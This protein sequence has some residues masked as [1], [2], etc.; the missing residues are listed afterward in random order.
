MSMKTTT[1]QCN[2]QHEWHVKTGGLP[3]Q[4]KSKR[5]TSFK[6]FKLFSWQE[7]KYTTHQLSSPELQDCPCERLVA[8][9]LC[10]FIFTCDFSTWTEI[11]FPSQLGVMGVCSPSTLGGSTEETTGAKAPSSQA[12][13]CCCPHFTRWLFSADYRQKVD[14]RTSQSEA[15]PAFPHPRNK[16]LSGHSSYPLTAPQIQHER[17]AIKVHFPATRA[18]FIL[19]TTLWSLQRKDNKW[20]WL[21]RSCYRWLWSL[22][23]LAVET[24]YTSCNLWGVSVWPK[25]NQNPIEREKW[26]RKQARF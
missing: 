18:E 24:Q 16:F 10:V 8:A 1:D 7:I 17:H 22:A 12:V 14:H 3:E 13:F 2:F 9:N 25:N 15:K 20:P 11:C 4:I 6:S 5:Q 21:R 19:K 26:D 23:G